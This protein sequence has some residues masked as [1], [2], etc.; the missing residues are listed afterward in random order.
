MRLLAEQK[1]YLENLILRFRPDA[2][3]YLFG[4]RTDVNARGG[5]V[6]ILVFARPKLNFKETASISREFC[7]KFEEQKIDILSYT[8]ESSEPFKNLALFNAIKF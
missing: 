2:E 7:L 6:D 5:D 4:S 8:P 1:Q 3:I